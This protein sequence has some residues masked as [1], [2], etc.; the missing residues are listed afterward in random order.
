MSPS[1]KFDGNLE[2]L[3]FQAQTLATEHP[4]IFINTLCS[5]AKLK[6]FM[7]LCEIKPED[8]DDPYAETKKRDL[9]LFLFDNEI[10]VT[11]QGKR[12]YFN[13]PKS[14]ETFLDSW[15]AFLPAQLVTQV[16]A[17]EQDLMG[18]KLG[19]LLNTASSG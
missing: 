2:S 9:L 12:L 5:H 17:T 6:E 11:K 13:D 1:Q 15:P 4:Q 8:K 10:L 16:Q 14:R 3:N 7:G 18:K 19:Q